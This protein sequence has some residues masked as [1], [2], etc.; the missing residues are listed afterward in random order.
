MAIVVDTSV[1][2]PSNRADLVAAAILQTTAP[3]HIVLTDSGSA[4]RGRIEAWQFGHADLGCIN[5]GGYHVARTPRQIRVAPAPDLMVIMSPASTVRWTQGDTQYEI[6]PGQLFLGDLN[7]PFE[8]GWQGGEVMTLQVPLDRLGVSNET[9]RRAVGLLSASPLQ[10]LVATQLALL[11]GSADLI[12][13][14]PAARD[15]SDMCVDLVRALLT[16]E[17]ANRGDGTVMPADMLLAQIRDYVRRHLTDADLSPARI[18]RAHHISC[19]YLYKLCAQA[20]FGLH[21]WIIR[22][23]LHHVRRELVSPRQQHRP[24][25]AVAQQYGFRDPSHFTRR[26]RS[27]FGVTPR[28]WRSTAHAYLP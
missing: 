4:V 26:F 14:D 8:A 13:N 18:A 6:A 1:V 2:E 15:F 16:S 17:A 27:A 5:T 21:E 20:N 12:E 11:I 7:Q 28:E 9:I 22:E 19:R 25:A 24:I 23:R 10:P 3:A